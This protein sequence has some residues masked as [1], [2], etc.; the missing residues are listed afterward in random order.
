MGAKKKIHAQVVEL[1]ATL[2]HE[3]LGE[4]GV[5][6]L[7]PTP[8]ELWAM[9]LKLAEESGLKVIWCHYSNVVPLGKKEKAA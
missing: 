1:R 2:K 3:H 4:A 8:E 5:H 9:H 7:D 6:L